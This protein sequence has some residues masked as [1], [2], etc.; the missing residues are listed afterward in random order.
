MIKEGLRQ[1]ASVT[2][3]E[4]P[5]VIGALPGKLKKPV[6]EFVTLNRA[7]LLQY[8]RN[9]ISTRQMLEGLVRVE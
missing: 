9:E 6:I 1:A 3:T 2:I 5:R 7:I 8:W 4:P